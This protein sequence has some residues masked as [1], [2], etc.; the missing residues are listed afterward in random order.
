MDRFGS[1]QNLITISP[2]LPNRRGKRPV[3]IRGP[4]HVQCGDYGDDIA[5]RH[6]VDEVIAWPDIEAGPLPVGS[7]DLVSLQV[8]EDVATGDPSVFITGREFGRVLFGAPTIH[9]ALP[10]GC[11]HWAIIRGW[12][13]PHFS[14]SFGLVP[15]GVMV[16]YTPRDEHEVAVCRSLFWASYNRSL[17]E[18]R[19]NSA[20]WNAPWSGVRHNSNIQEPVAVA[21]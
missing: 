1:A 7:A 9:L 21:E 3:T 12:A 11:A 14:S 2:S 8:G 16:V 18:R 6:L 10:L 19:K 15:P 4:L 17:S 5:L 13:E 20:E